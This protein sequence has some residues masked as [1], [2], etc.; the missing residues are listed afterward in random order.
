MSEITDKK[1]DTTIEQKRRG[2][3]TPRKI[4]STRLN[5]GNSFAGWEALD[6][7]EFVSPP[8]A[9][10]FRIRFKSQEGEI[11]FDG[12]VKIKNTATPSSGVGS[13]VI[14][15]D[16][17]RIFL[18]VGGSGEGEGGRYIVLSN[19]DSSVYFGL[20][21]NDDG[22]Y[23]LAMVGLPSSDPGI[24]GALYHSAGTLKVSL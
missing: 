5:K 23:N 3:A 4:R 18:E 14:T 6:N 22:T 19:A 24:P 13:M 10:G 15:H 11:T 7:G 1:I 12:G 16:T 20:I 9:N 17:E 2:Y 21:D 8:D